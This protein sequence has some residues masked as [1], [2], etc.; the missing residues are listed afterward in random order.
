MPTPNPFAGVINQT[1]QTPCAVDP[2]GPP[3]CVDWSNFRSSIYYGEFQPNLKS[4]Y[5]E[6]YPTVE[7]QLTKD[8]LLRVSYVGTQA[9]HLLASYDQNYGHAETCLGLNNLPAGSVLT[10]PVAMGGTPTSP[11][12]SDR[13]RSITFSPT[14]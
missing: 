14:P 11:G 3:G 8:M 9:H 4:Q 12:R 7:R 13:M 1:P 5:A 6:Q 2:N 10:A